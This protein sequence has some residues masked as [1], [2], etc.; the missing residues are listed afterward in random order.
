MNLIVSRDH[1]SLAV[2]SGEVLGPVS[3]ML[4][5]Y[6]IRLLYF[7]PPFHI[8]GFEEFVNLS[9]SRDVKIFA[10]CWN[11]DSTEPLA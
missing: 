1:H 7:L 3:D 4:I 2:K 9:V 5:I 8:T 6:I 11:F 10:D